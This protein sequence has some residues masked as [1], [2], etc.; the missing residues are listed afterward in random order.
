VYRSK[1]SGDEPELLGLTANDGALQLPASDGRL[2]TLLVRSGNQLLARLPVVPGQ[3]PE[4]TAKIVDDDGRLQAEGL[5]LA[6]QSRVMD[7]VARR[8]LIAAEFRAQV[9]A[10]KLKEAQGLLDEYRQL[11]SRGDLSR[12]LDRQQQ[13]ITSPDRLTQLRIQKM[14]GDARKLLLKYLDPETANQLARDL[15][16][17]KSRAVQTKSAAER[18]EGGGK[19]APAN[20]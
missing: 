16:I 6:L 5:V 8:E 20:D 14:F 11:E 17:A 18:T 19:S 15:A 4:L 2:Q 1:G 10:G 3:A 9:A 13:E 12:V 7:L